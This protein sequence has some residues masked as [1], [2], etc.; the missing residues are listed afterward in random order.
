MKKWLALIL[1]AA[2]G[3]VTVSSYAATTTATAAT[4]ASTAAKAAPAKAAPKAKKQHKV[5]TSAA[6]K[7]VAKTEVKK[8]S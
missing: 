5:H 1:S 8:P 4:P 3:F 7:K 6:S 2:F